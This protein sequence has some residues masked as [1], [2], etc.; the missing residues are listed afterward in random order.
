MTNTIKGWV[1]NPAKFARTHG[2][3]VSNTSHMSGGEEQVHILIVEGFLLYNYQ[4]V[5][6][7]KHAKTH[8]SSSRMLN[9][10]IGMSWTFVHISLFFIKVFLLSFELKMIK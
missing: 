5:H 9:N 2:V 3:T 10:L 8:T 7:H 1:E 6:T 4:Y